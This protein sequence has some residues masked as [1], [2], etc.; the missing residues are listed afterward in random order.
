LDGKIKFQRNGEIFYIPYSLNDVATHNVQLKI[1]DN[2]RFLI[3]QQKQA[4]G[5]V[6][7]GT[8]FA[9]RVELLPIGQLMQQQMPKQLY[10]GI[11]TSLKDSFGRIEREDTIKETFF[12]F[13]EYKGKNPAQ[14]LR[15][16]LNVE[17]ELENKFGKEIACNIRM[18]PD[19]SVSFDELSRKVFV[20]RISQAPNQS[21][22]G[23]LIFENTDERL[24]ELA[25][26]EQDRIFSHTL[27][28]GDFVQFR[29]ATDKRRML[30]QRATQLSLLEDIALAA[31]T[32]NTQEHRERG[33]LVKL[34]SSS[35]LLN[36][37]SMNGNGSSL[38]SSQQVNTNEAKVYGVIKC[39]E[40]DDLAYF[41]TNEVISY[42]KLSADEQA[43]QQMKL[44][45]NE[46]KLE[47]G[48]SLEFCLIRCQK[49]SLLCK[50][51]LKAIRI[52]KL[53]KNSVQFKL[54][55]DELH[56]G[57]VEKEASMSESTD[58]ATQS[59]GLI[60]YDNNTKTIIYHFVQPMDE[61][62]ELAGTQTP[63][64]PTTPKQ[65]NQFTLGDKVQFK[66][67]S[68]LRTKIQYAV[69]LKFVE[70]R[71]EQGIITMIKDNY[72]FIELSPFGNE[73]TNKSNS[74]PMSRDMFFHF[75]S[76]QYSSNDIDVGDEVEFTINR[77]Q[78][79]KLFAECVQKLGPKAKQHIQAHDVNISPLV[80]KGRVIQPL[81]SHS[82]IT[83]QQQQQQ[84][85]GASSSQEQ[86]DDLYFG[87]IQLL[88]NEN[89]KQSKEDKEVY[90]FGLFGLN[91]KKLF[92]QNGDLVSFQLMD[93]PKSNSASF[94]SKKAVNI[95]LIQASNEISSTL[96]SNA[97]A[98]SRGELKRGKIES[99]KG[100]VSLRCMHAHHSISNLH[101]H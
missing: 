77:K 31:N 81:R 28:E 39:L 11:I 16:G 78:K 63:T 14:E 1:G 55:N 97:N 100:H 20:G 33:V 72:G 26:A 62:D 24:A 38:M 5:A 95:Q 9:R 60:R 90:Q 96:A 84:Q 69:D 19:G 22:V 4:N 34:Y 6:P 17:F 53:P 49:D 44:I 89:N 87:K 73:F 59:T 25:F 21:V 83:Q 30:K 54:I 8:Y 66:I 94:S 92:L 41:T 23:R 79:Q 91:D 42:A 56:L 88:T 93:W 18:L 12:H 74:S 37:K 75:S 48:D 50:S 67:C 47:E 85:N 64:S 76:L 46:T 51:G 52:C 40:Q 99:I 35:E 29:I 71:K 70:S 43:P 86:I 2:V 27:L 80:L 15:V 82:S 58:A 36:S 57:F 32:K 98:R 13:T 65:T 101:S 61:L 3:G 10:R 68:C 45:L 7:V